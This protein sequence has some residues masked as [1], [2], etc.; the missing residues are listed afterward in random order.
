MASEGSSKAEW[1]K[2]RKGLITTFV[3]AIY[4]V[5]DHWGRGEAALDIYRLLPKFFLSISPYIAPML[6]FL[7]LVFFELQRRHARADQRHKWK[8]IAYGGLVTVLVVAIILILLEPNVRLHIAA[9]TFANVLDA[10]VSPVTGVLFYPV[11]V[12]NSGSP[13][14]L[15]GW[16]AMM[17]LM[18]GESFEGDLISDD[19]KGNLGDTTRIFVIKKETYL[20]NTIS[21]KP[22]PTGGRAPGAIAFVFAGVRRETVDFPGTKLILECEDINGRKYSADFV[23]PAK[24]VVFQNAP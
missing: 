7:A 4:W 20:Q 23:V 11:F 17:N 9:L 1:Y 8:I 10:P 15:N 24:T 22:I 12:T 5:L 18:D 2:S 3:G 21:N 19:W 14:T 16:R 6:F 13:T